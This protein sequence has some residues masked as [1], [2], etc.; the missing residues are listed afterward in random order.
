MRHFCMLAGEHYYDACGAL[1]HTVKT[2]EPAFRHVFGG[3][4]YDVMMKDPEAALV[5][6]KAMADLTRPVAALVAARHDFSGVSTII[7]VG[8]G[9]GTMLAGL[10]SAHKHLRGT[11]IDRED[12]CARAAA[13]LRASGDEDLADRLSFHGQSFFES[14]P[15]GGDVYILKNV[16]H[17]WGHDSSLRIL[18]Q[19]AEAMRRK[20]ASGGRAPRLL[21]IEALVEGTDTSLRKLVDALFQVALCE[22]GTRE[23]TEAEMR[24]LLGEAGLG[25]VAIQQLPTELAVI[26]CTL[27][28]AG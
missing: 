14:L 27:A 9:S 15:E 20:V 12:V 3:S 1:L 8:G 18:R 21:V 5:Y 2:G 17:N 4:I 24:G 7:D 19:I 26:E 16:L 13:A 23:R 11:C 28:G 22:E 25:V 10:L 6:D